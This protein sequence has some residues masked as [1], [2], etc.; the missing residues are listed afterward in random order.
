MFGAGWSSRYDM[1]ITPDDDGSGNV[2][3]T[4]P[5]GQQVRFGAD[6]D[7]QG[8]PTGGRLA[9]PPGRWATLVPQTGGGWLLTDKSNTT[10]LFAADGTLSRTTDA[11]GRAV[12]LTYESG[13][14]KTARNTTSNRTLTFTWAGNHVS[15]VA[16]DAVNG[17]TSTWRYNY[18]TGTDRLST[19]CDPLSNCTTYSYQQGTHFRSAVIDSNPDS[20]WRFREDSGTDA[21]S[22]VATNLGK[23][24]GRLTDVTRTAVG[25]GVAGAG[26]RAASFNGTTSAV[27]LPQGLIKKSREVTVELWFKTGA[28]GPLVGAQNTPLGTAPANTVPVLYVGTDGKLRGQF[29]HGAVDPITSTAA[30]NDN[31]WHHVAL[32]STVNRQWLYLDGQPVG[33]RTGT[34]DNST[35]THVLVGASQQ[36]NTTDWAGWGST[37]RRHFSGQ[38]DEVAV[39]QHTVGQLAITAHRAALDP[40]DQ[41]TKVALP[42]GKVA[43]EVS[44]DVQRDRMHTLVDGNG[45]RWTLSEPVVSGPSREKM[46]RTVRVIDPGNRS[47]FY[48]YDPLRGRILRY[49]APLGM[50]VRPEDR[51]TQPTTTTTTTTCVSQPGGSFCEVPIGGGPGSFVPVEMQGARTYEYDE[52]G[53]QSKITDETGNRVTLQHDKRGNIVS[54]TSCR[55]GLSDCQTSYFQFFA[56]ESNL[57]DPRLD[58]VIA[59][60]DG[61]SA[62]ATD[63]T[64]KTSYTYTALGELDTQTTPDGAVVRHLYTDG[65]QPAVGGGNAPAGLVRES[66]DARGAVTRY[67]YH[68]TG[69]LAE[70]TTPAGLVTTYTYDALGRRER[71][72]QNGVFSAT[73]YDQLSR[74]D[75]VTQPVV[76]NP[77]TGVSHQ[78]QVRTD[79]TVDGFPERVEAKDLTGGDATRTATTEYDDRNRVRRLVDAEGLETTFGYDSSGNRTWTVGPDGVKYEYAYT[80]RN[81]VAEV[82]LRGWRDQWRPAEPDEETRPVSPDD[83]LVV[84]AYDYD[85]AGEL[86]GQ[87]DAMGR[88]TGYRYYTDGSLKQTYA[89]GFHDE[90]GSTRDIVLADFSYDNAGNLTKV[91]GTGNRVTTTEYDR[92]GRIT[93]TTAD[94]NGLKRRSALTYDLNG[95]VTKVVR[96]GLESN[97]GSQLVSTDVE[98][99]EFGYDAAGRQTSERVWVDGKW[100][101][102][103][104]GYNAQNQLTS[105]HDPRGTSTT[106]EISYDVLGRVIGTRAP[107]VSVEAGDGGAAVRTRPETKAGYNT[108]GQP[109]ESVDAQGRTSRATFDK[110]GRL[111]DAFAPPYTPPGSTSVITPRLTHRD[112]DGDGN[113]AAV[114]DARGA[115]TRMR[116]DQMN[117]VVEVAH[118]H[119]TTPGES[120]GTSSF[121]YTRVGELLSSVN[122]DGGRA[123]RTY[124]DLGRLVTA[125]QL[126]RRPQP[127][128]FTSRFKYADS[129]DLLEKVSAGGS[130]STF[131]YDAVGALTKVV[132]PAGVPTHYGYDM[133]GRPATVKDALGRSTRTNYDTAGRVK[134]S[135]DLNPLG[136]L[137]RRSSVTY[138]AAG[139]VETTRDPLN[140]TTTFTYDALSRVVQQAEPESVTTS[141]GYDAAGNLTRYTNGKQIPT[142]NTYNS[143]GLPEK[144]VEPSTAAHPNAADRTWVTSY[145]TGGLPV[146]AVAPGGVARERTFD[147]RGQLTRETGSGAEAPTVERV[148]AYD[149]LGRLT[150]ASAPGGTNTFTHNDRGQLLTADGPSGTSSFGYDSD[151]RVTTRSD[152]SGASTYAYLNGRLSSVQ[153]ALTGTLQV[154]SYN[155]VGQV[156]AMEYGGGRKREF[157]YDDLARLKADKVGGAS[158]TYTYDNGNQLKTATSAGFAGPALQEY[159]YDALGRLTSWKSDGVETA[160]GWDA[161]GNRTSAAGKTATFDERNRLL[162]DGTDSYVH[163]PRGTTVS[164]GAQQSKFDAFNRLA[165]Q[166]AATYSYDGLDRVVKRNSTTFAYSGTGNDL[167][168]DGSSTFSRGPGADLLAVQQNGTKRLAVANGRSDVIGSLDPAS[169]TLTDTTS[170]DPFGKVVGG[171]KRPLGYQGDWTDQETDQVNMSARWYDPSRGAFSSRDSAALPANPSSFAHRYNYGAGAPTNF[172]DPNGMRPRDVTCDYPRPYPYCYENDHA[173]GKPS[174]GM[175]DKINPPSSQGGDDC[176][177]RKAF[178]GGGCDTPCNG[179]GRDPSLLVSFGGGSSCVNGS[180]DGDTEP[181]GRNP[182]KPNGYNYAPPPPPD[183]AIAARAENRRAAMNN[184]MPIPSALGQP[185]YGDS[186]DPPV[187]SSPQTPSHQFADQVDPVDGVA[188]TY[189]KIEQSITRA[190]VLLMKDVVALG[191]SLELNEPNRPDG[192]LFQAQLKKTWEDFKADPNGFGQALT[193]GLWHVS[194]DLLGLVPVVGELA[195]GLNALFYAAEGKWLEAE[196]SAAAM[197]PGIGIGAT[198][199]KAVA[200]TIPSDVATLL[201]KNAGTPDAYVPLLKAPWPREVKELVEQGFTKDRFPGEP[202]SKRARD[203]DPDG[204][205]YF[206]TDQELAI[207]YALERRSG[208]LQV[209]VPLADYVQ[210][211]QQFEKTYD[212]GPHTELPVP[213]TMFDLLNS[214][215]RDYFSLQ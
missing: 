92:V 214:Y 58:K 130:R 39:Y 38:I 91:V 193:T 71:T 199:G 24:T 15:T 152:A 139:N 202:F 143:L 36:L 56:D 33:D 13:K 126:E 14:L 2:V 162:N 141:F 106:A 88:K 29:W 80:A 73:T 213:N 150:S 104:R 64:Y 41:L 178:S 3:V 40:A 75:S 133:V 159:G 100:L 172:V 70:V 95:N 93:A 136:Q 59:A 154:A 157:E 116:Y 182:N 186:F 183:P 78:L 9:P 35:L 175:F 4:Y 5:D 146:R 138:D 45:G 51:P 191:S 103:V 113:L 27:A 215:K 50:E 206:T 82:R 137:L 11:A 112:Y 10:H 57:T 177:A 187:S 176:T 118:P 109:T 65:N 108:F 101:T 67:R 7:A 148:M 52:A 174:P 49:L 190:E 135:V 198:A 97:T 147:L 129:G 180:G 194:L 87:T 43:A 89:K 68:A 102:T 168:S 32:T 192:D 54:R 208:V 211:F 140:R 166:G 77:V 161:A 158:K 160:Y 22:E 167:A 185:L 42:S 79:Y 145:D 123:E 128:T 19:V 72:T 134:N 115:V 131:S 196:L 173:E 122:A 153:D 164:K 61:R 189:Q 120:Q 1:R 6:L 86:V 47:H 96:S 84:A 111:V 200:K 53:F 48:D 30:V 66:T 207:K 90:D 76:K 26:D 197:V 83:H 62:S 28:G 184:P 46:V 20:F 63:D 132:D 142:Y 107:E 16:T 110:L 151:G 44:Y 201:V 121:T 165:S 8:R 169:G 171:I 156:K 105:I 212:G 25:E 179:A 98:T 21:R 114:T 155:E 170:Y 204:F 60:R 17:K 74:V 205:A 81:M 34:I 209:K 195:D 37:V 12:A 69:D 99:V 181:G 55:S 18:E 124:D 94:P 144:T 163:S 125:T 85:L 117:R 127:G 203:S 31:R 119:P 210:H 23:D 149:V 188:M